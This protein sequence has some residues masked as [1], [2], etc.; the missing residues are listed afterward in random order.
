LEPGAKPLPAG[1]QSSDA[2]PAPARADRAPLDEA[3][4]LAVA[5]RQ[6]ASASVD[7]E[8]ASAQQHGAHALHLVHQLQHQTQQDDEEDRKLL[9]EVE[10][11][12]QRPLTAAERAVVWHLRRQGKNARQIVPEL[13]NLFRDPWGG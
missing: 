4:H 1:Q 9:A 11:L 8:R 2:S 6:Q 5:W 12:L 10:A 13:P 7:K 3:A